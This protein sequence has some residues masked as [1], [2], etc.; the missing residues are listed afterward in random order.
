MTQDDQLQD[1]L[2]RR[3]WPVIFLGGIAI[4]APAESIRAL[5]QGGALQLGLFDGRKLFEFA[6]PDYPNQPLAACRNDSS[7]QHAASAAQKG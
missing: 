3:G 4:A 6:H 5:V 1:H 7:C 2:D